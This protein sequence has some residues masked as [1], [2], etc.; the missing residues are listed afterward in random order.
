[1]RSSITPRFLRHIVTS[2]STRSTVHSIDLLLGEQAPVR[3]LHILTRI[4]GG[5][6]EDNTLY[7]CSGL[8]HLGYQVDLAIGEENEPASIRKTGIDPSVRIS[9]IHGLRRNPAPFHETRAIRN[10]RA[11]IRTRGYHIVHTHG[12]KAGV[13][14]RIAAAK[15]HVPIIIHGI[16]GTSFSP[17]MGAISRLL[18]RNIER[19]IAA[20]TDAFVCVGEDMRRQYVDASIGTAE[21]YHIIHSG[22]NLDAFRAAGEIQPA[23]SSIRTE[24]GIP[25]ESVVIG[26]ISRME[27]RKQHGLFL[28]SISLLLTRKPPQSDVRVLI[29]G[30]GPLEEEIKTRVNDLGLSTITRFAGYRND[31]ESFFSASD[32]VTL[33]SKWEGLPRV[34]VQ[35]A[36]VGRPVVTFD[37]DGAW[38][39][40]EDGTT[41]LIVPQGDVSGFAEALSLLIDDAAKRTI[42][43]N[44][45]RKRVGDQ[46]TIET[47]VSRT[48]DLYRKLGQDAFPRNLDNA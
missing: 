7:T 37:V 11:L 45:A 23:S 14:G 24:F 36:A 38:E 46:W 1:M 30:D 33:T 25:R 28:Q 19:W 2:V 21:Q 20:K 4:A 35:A 17:Q 3:V 40:V 27:A 8:S 43:G 42:M 5:G 16:H 10:L 13:L 6:A 39:I 32:V 31:V 22:M 12:S 18:Y 34:L 9:I 48:D 26:M 47:M 15:E 44:R 29:V 41:G